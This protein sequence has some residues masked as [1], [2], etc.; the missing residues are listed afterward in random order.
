MIIL[1]YFMGDV[2]DKAL[3]GQLYNIHKLTGISILIL[4]AL[5]LLW[6]A[7]NPKPKLPLGTPAWELY[8]ER[9]MHYLLYAVLLAMPISGWVMASAAGHPPRLFSWII[10]LPI[11]KSK[12]VD[13]VSDVIHSTL[14][15]VIIVLVSLHVLAALYHYCFRKD[16]VMQRMLL[17]D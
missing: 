8:A 12:P 9:T 13:D 10:G 17:G 2:K 3:S 4:M 15:I 16:D 5:R 7:V 14:A 6:A 1:G 11:A